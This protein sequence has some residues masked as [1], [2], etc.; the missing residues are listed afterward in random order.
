MAACT[1]MCRA[2]W[3]VDEG[4]NLYFSDLLGGT[5]TTNYIGGRVYMTDSSQNVIP[6]AGQGNTPI[7]ASSA[8][9]EASSSVLNAPVGL[10]VDRFLETWIAESGNNSL[11]YIF[12]GQ[13]SPEGGLG[14]TDASTC[15]AAKPCNPAK[16]SV[17]YAL[18]GGFR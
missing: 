5:Y 7:V 15:T 10:A 6:L 14:T 13:I 1:S 4:D 18:L 17:G 16:V 8:G 9:V 11:D 2:T 3:T 12:A